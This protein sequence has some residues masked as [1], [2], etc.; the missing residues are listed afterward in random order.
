MHPTAAKSFASMRLYFACICRTPAAC[1]TFVSMRAH[2]NAP[3]C[4]QTFCVHAPP[5]WLHLGHGPCMQEFCQHPCACAR[6]GGSMHRACKT[7]SMH[8]L[9]TRC[10]MLALACAS[11]RLR[12]HGSGFKTPPW[13][14]H[15]LLYQACVQNLCVH[16]S[17]LIFCRLHPPACPSMRPTTHHAPSLHRPLPAATCSLHARK[18]I[19]PQIRCRRSRMH[20]LHAHTLATIAESHAR[21]HW[22]PR[23]QR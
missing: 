14:M 18:C 22:H 17:A 11:T 16:A 23:G 13:S 3:E 5:F 4:R 15:V 9:F 1:K 2:A 8:A 21:A 12:I 10:C 19:Y 20:R 6:T 7:F